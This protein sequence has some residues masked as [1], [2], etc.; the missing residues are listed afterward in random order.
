[1]KTIINKFIFLIIFTAVIFSF[2]NMTSNS[3]IAQYYFSDG[4]E[5]PVFEGTIIPNVTTK[6]D[7][8]DLGE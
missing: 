3:V 5:V 1:M 2:I 6:F 4:V 7:Y 8:W